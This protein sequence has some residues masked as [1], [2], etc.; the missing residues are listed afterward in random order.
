[1]FGWFVT[2]LFPGSC[3]FSFLLA[4]FLAGVT[5]QILIQPFQPFA[6]CLTCLF[7]FLLSDCHMLDNARWVFVAASV[8]L[9]GLG[10]VFYW[11]VTAMGSDVMST[12]L[13][14]AWEA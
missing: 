4:W 1:V 2:L 13:N 11:F 8:M 9:V 14:K 5:G 12:L 3:L 7:F 10:P 6:G